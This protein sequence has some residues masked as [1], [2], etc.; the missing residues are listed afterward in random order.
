MITG[1]DTYGN[2]IKTTGRR[3]LRPVVFIMKTILFTENLINKALPFNPLS[4]V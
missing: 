4:Q 2:N 3:L 1:L